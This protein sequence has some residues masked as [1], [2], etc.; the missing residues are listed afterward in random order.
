MQLRVAQIVPDT[1][2]EGPGRRCAIWVQGCSLRCPGCCNPEMFSSEKSGSLVEVEVLAR[3]ILGRS[4]LSGVTLL[5]GEPFEQAPAL[6]ELCQELAAADLSVMIFSGY[7]LAELKAMASPQVATLLSLADI[8]VDGR[9]EQ[10]QPESVRRWV[11]SSNQVIHFLTPRYSATDARF[12]LP[13]TV[14]LRL[15]RGQLTING[16]PRLADAVRRR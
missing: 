2:A 3:E 16:W 4:E 10:G 1:E 13:N 12:L 5:G 8:L 15:E 6:V 14:E 11:G 9:F 7:T